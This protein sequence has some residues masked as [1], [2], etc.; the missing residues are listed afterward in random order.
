MRTFIVKTACALGCFLLAAML[1]AGEAGGKGAKGEGRRGGRGPGGSADRA[2]P[3][4]TA[5]DD[6]EKKI[7]EV[8]D[9]VR[10]QGS[11]EGFPGLNVPQWDGRL[12]RLLAESTGAKQVV[13]FGTSNGYSGLWFALALRTTGGKLTTFD[14]DP[15]KVDLARANFKKAGVDGIVTVIEGDAHKEFAKAVQGPIDLVFIDA[16]KEGYTQYLEQVL[17]L[18]RPGGLIV[19]HNIP[20]EKRGEG[21]A[22]EKFVDAAGK[23]PALETLLFFGGNGISVSMKKR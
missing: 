1:A 13:E 2:S 22:L 11:R 19:A 18:V 20:R 8:L 5:K 9:E 4:P 16:E 17:P 10:G 12:L 23:N 3:E 15:K 21:D 6:A 7:L 14:L